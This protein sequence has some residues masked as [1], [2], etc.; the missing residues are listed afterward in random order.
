MGILIKDKELRYQSANKTYLEWYGA[1]MEDLRGKTF[2][3]TTGFQEDNDNSSV[4]KQEREVLETGAIVERLSARNFADG[5]QHVVRITKF[6][7]HDGKGEISKIGSV[8]VDMTEQIVIQ[9]ELEAANKR[10]DAAN[11]A[12]SAI[13]GT[14]EPRAADAPLIQSSDFLTWSRTETLGPIENKTYVQY[15]GYIQQSASH[16]LDVI[17]DI[18]DIS[19]IEAGELELDETPTGLGELVD[20][21]MTLASQRA[22][23]KKLN[24][25]SEIPDDLPLL[26]LDDRMIKQVMVNLLSNAVKFTPDGGAVVVSAKCDPDR[27]I[28]VS[29]RDTGIGMAE[30]DI[31]RAM[32][33]FEQVGEAHG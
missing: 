8:S 4:E 22:A 24:V 25:S 12:K 14:Y 7:I 6:P 32:Q 19:K 26:L 28:L 15:A 13:S 3:E 5:K 21:A 27:Q 17:N 23:G 20:D 18:L 33:P 2:G 1:T 9:E 11:R 30:K 10:L 29:V 31:P 16:L